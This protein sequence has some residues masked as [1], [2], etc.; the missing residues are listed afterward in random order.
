[1]ASVGLYL[2]TVLIW[3]TT[4]IAVTMQTGAVATESSVSYRF[5]IAALLFLGYALLA[6][7]RLR[8]APVDHAW[9]AMQGFLLALTFVCIYEATMRIASGLVSI[10]FSLVAV[11]NVV[12]MQ[13]F[14]RARTSSGALSGAVLG[15][16]GVLLVFG[17]SSAGGAQESGPAIGLAASLAAALF[18]ALAGMAIVR[19]QR[20]Q[21]PMVSLNGFSLLYGAAFAGVL[22]ALLG[23]PFTVTWEPTYLGSLLYLSIVGS[24]LVFAT[25]LELIR[26]I[27]AARAGYV[28]VASPVVA[29][30]V[31]GAFEAL[32]VDLLGC[33]GLLACLA[34]NILVL[35][36]GEAVAP[37]APR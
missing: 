6:R 30:F 10:V 1:M 28:A 21:I 24:V 37:A 9:M 4:W 35:K 16:V 3:G 18:A 20:R 15:V 34:G 25:Y 19:N 8:F 31:S 17:R 27:G 23:K 32:R 33:I 29:L 12:G 2:L 11:L 7:V 22:A 5:A 14:F 13:L 26:R 36:D